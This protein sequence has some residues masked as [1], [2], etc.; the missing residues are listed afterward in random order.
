[1]GDF[2]TNPW[3]AAE[4]TVFTALCTATGSTAK[5]NAFLGYLPA[6][7][8]VWALKVGGGGDVRNTWGAP[9]GITELRMDAEIEAQ[10]TERARAQ[11]FAL[12]VLDALPIARTGNVQL[13]RLRAGGM[14]DIKFREMTLANTE[15]PVILWAVTIGCE[16]VFNT[17]TRVNADPAV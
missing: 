9:A 12:K 13:F 16:I 15:N 1:M 8:N 11:E 7:G 10:F 3:A 14:P 6:V 5:K 2:M 4:G 17:V